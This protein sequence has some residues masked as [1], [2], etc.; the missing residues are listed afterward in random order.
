MEHALQW[1]KDGDGLIE[2]GGYA[3]QTFDAWTMTGVR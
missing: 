1:D 3:D 2:N